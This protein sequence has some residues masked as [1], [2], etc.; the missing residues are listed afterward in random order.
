MPGN[1]REAIGRAVSAWLLLTPSPH[2]HKAYEHDL[3]QFL[4]AV[5]IEAG[6]FER[7]PEARPEHISAWGDRLASGGMTIC[8]TQP[9]SG[10]QTPEGSAG[11]GKA[12]L[13]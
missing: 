12:A 10:K 7:L 9:R 6:A 5:G 1:L 4:T 3:N 11:T 13:R 8:S 2:T